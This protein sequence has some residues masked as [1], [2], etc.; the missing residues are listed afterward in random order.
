MPTQTFRGCGSKCVESKGKAVNFHSL[1]KIEDLIQF[2][3]GTHSMLYE[4]FMF[5]V[6]ASITGIVASVV[7]G[8]LLCVWC[9]YIGRKRTA[10]P[11][12]ARVN[13]VSH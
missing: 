11:P 9:A 13:Q 3:W 12:S 10:W 2:F 6:V 4:I 8:G 5:W 7:L 1:R